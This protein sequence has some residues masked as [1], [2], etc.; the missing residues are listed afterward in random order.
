M[1]DE[2]RSAAEE[3]P[4]SLAQEAAPWCS[5]TLESFLDCIGYAQMT[6]ETY[7]E[8]STVEI[9]TPEGIIEVEEAVSLAR[10]GYVRGRDGAT[11]YAILEVLGQVGDDDDA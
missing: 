1:T 6:W 3:G 8:H 11:A 9:D 10:N 2:E 5:L 7:G 4:Y